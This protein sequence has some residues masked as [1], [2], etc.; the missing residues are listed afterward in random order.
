MSGKLNRTYQRYPNPSPP[1]LW[2]DRLLIQQRDD[3][4]WLHRWKHTFFTIATF[5]AA[6]AIPLSLWMFHPETDTVTTILTGFVTL[7]TGGLIHEITARRA[8]QAR[9]SDRLN[10]MRQGYETLLALLSRHRDDLEEAAPAPASSPLPAPSPSPPSSP[11]L[12]PTTPTPTP[13]VPLQPP[14]RVKASRSAATDEDTDMAAIVREA[15]A[16]QRV[17]FHLQPIVS[18]SQRKHRFYEVLSRIRLPNRQLLAA[19]RYLA[20]AQYER[21]LPAIDV[22][23]LERVAQLVRETDRRQ[24]AVSFFANVSPMTLLDPNFS[25]RFL[26]SVDHQS[27]RTKLM[28]EIDQHDIDAAVPAVMTIL[29]DMKR[30]EYRFSLGQ[31]QHLDINIDLTLSKNIHFIKLNAAMLVDPDSRAQVVALQ[32]RLTGRP[33]ELIAERIENERQLAC[34]V[35]LGIAYG[36]GFLVGEPRPSRRTP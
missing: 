15:L 35:G 36:Q 4:M 34:A 31:V 12:D 27:L 19:E 14:P 13:V 28:F 2:L 17:E 9:P 26:R 20:V 8:A 18:L 3:T 33:I 30:Q 7:L 29:E 5:A 24:H 23:L 25:A 11:S 16:E 6:L 21:L 10:R 32:A 22:L 1:K